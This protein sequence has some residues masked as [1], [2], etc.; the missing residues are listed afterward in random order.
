[1]TLI[2]NIL[3][4]KTPFY[5]IEIQ[6]YNSLC[7][8]I[9]KKPYDHKCTSRDSWYVAFFTFGEGFH[10][11]HHK[12]QWDYRN[13]IRWFHYDP[14]KWFIWLFSKIGLAKELKKVDTMRILKI[15]TI[16]IWQ[17]INENLDSIPEQI[18]DSYKMKLNDIKNK[19]NDLEESRKETD[20]VLKNLYYN[21]KK[22]LLSK[23]IFREK[24]KF[25]KIE[26]A[27]IINS[28]S[29]ILLSIRMEQF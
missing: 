22:I 6:Y 11:F 15:K 16:N 26:Y 14:S 28:L 8:F 9:G 20:K 7:H 21:K 5:K 10:N 23:N 29:A 1:M 19:L 2:L 3:I 4:D 24:N 27:S 17:E 18:R 25:Y 13:G 12:F